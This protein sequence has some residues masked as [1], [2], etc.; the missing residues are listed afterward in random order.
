MCDLIYLSKLVS[1]N[2]C[3][4]IVR[5]HSCACTTV[6]IK[7]ECRLPQRGYQCL[8]KH[9]IY[10]EVDFHCKKCFDKQQA[11]MRQEEAE[12]F[13]EIWMQAVAEAAAMERRLEERSTGAGT[14]H[15]LD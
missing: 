4:G 9:T 7:R 8:E 10:F 12:K 2:M 1:V 13:V 3:W 6:D 11:T 14:S 15:R 5:D